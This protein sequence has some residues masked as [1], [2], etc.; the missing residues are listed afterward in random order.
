MQ[1]YSTFGAFL[2]AFTMVHGAP[3][4]SEGRPSSIANTTADLGSSGP[5][6]DSRFGGN[7]FK[8]GTMQGVNDN[9]PSVDVIAE[10]DT[11]SA[12]ATSKRSDGTKSGSSTTASGTQK[13]PTAGS[14]SEGKG[15]IAKAAANIVNSGGLFGREDAPPKKSGAREGTQPKKFGEAKSGSSSMLPG[16]QLLG[17]LGSELIPGVAA[18]ARRSST[19]QLGR[20]Q[21]PPEG[22]PARGGPKGGNAGSSG[23]APGGQAA[24]GATGLTQGSGDIVSGGPRNGSA[25]AS[26]GGAPFRRD[27]ARPEGVKVRPEA[28]NPKINVDNDNPPNANPKNTSQAAGQAAQKQSSPPS[29]GG[30]SSEGVADAQ[31]GAAKV[32]AQDK[33]VEGRAVRTRAKSGTK[34]PPS[35]TGGGSPSGSSTSGTSDA[36]ESSDLDAKKPVASTSKPTLLTGT[37]GA[38][39]IGQAGDL[40]SAIST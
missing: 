12:G 37:I 2:V 36:G 4:V 25:G 1:L 40:I 23:K 26:A 29:G 32:S 10:D 27:T 7:G 33:I 6:P 17:G 34:Q 28:Q 22:A 9:T 38:A 15:A 19:S 16:S 21:S 20:G 3:I 30:S 18:P 24:G 39:A 35:S 31:R 8:P 13:K 14:S 5:G 11:S